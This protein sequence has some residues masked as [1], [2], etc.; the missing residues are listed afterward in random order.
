MIRHVESVACHAYLG[1]SGI[2]RM[3]ANKKTASPR[4]LS[5]L[6]VGAIFSVCEPLSAATITVDSDVDA[7]ISDGNC[8]LREAIISSNTDSPVDACTQGSGSDVI[9]LPAG[10]YILT[11]P[12]TN[13]NASADG[14]LDVTSNLTISGEDA[15]TTIIDGNGAITGERA[16]TIGSSGNSSFSVTISDVTI[17]NGA[18]ATIGGGILN[19]GNTTLTNIVVTGSTATQNGGGIYNFL[20][21]MTL[22]NATILQNTAATNGGGVYNLSTLTIIDSNVSNN[23][24]TT[25]FG[26]GIAA[27]GNNFTVTDSMI[28][29]NTAAISGGGIHAASGVTHI[30]GCTVSGNTVINGNGGGIYSDGGFEFNIAASTISGN[31]AQIGGGGV[32][33]G[34]GTALIINSIINGNTSLGDGGG[35][36]N[37]GALTVN[38]SDISENTAVNHGGGISNAANIA[39][40]STT[41]S[42]NTA[43]GNGGG[44]WNNNGGVQMNNVTITNNTA[45]NDADDSGDGGGLYTNIGL[46]NISNTLIA[47]NIDGSSSAE[48][49]DCL[50]DI[51]S[52]GNNIVG[53]DTGCNFT[54]NTGD[55]VGTTGNPVNPLLGPLADNGGDTRTHELLEESPAIDT[56]N[57]ASCE[58]QDQ[59]GIDRPQDGNN[60]NVAICD[61]GSFELQ[62]SPNVVYVDPVNPPDDLQMPF[63]RRVINTFPTLD[64][65]VTNSGRLDLL[66]RRIG[67]FERLEPP[68]SLDEDCTTAPIPPSGSCVITVQFSVAQVGQFS[69]SFDIITNDPDESIVVVDVSGEG[70]LALNNTPPSAPELIAPENGA[71]GQDPDNVDFQWTRADDPDNDTLTYSILLCTDA[72]LFICPDPQP[73]QGLTSSIDQEYLYAGLGTSGILFGLFG[74]TS[75]RIQRRTRLGLLILASLAASPLLISC[76]TGLKDVDVSSALNSTPLGVSFG[77]FTP[78]TTYYWRIDVADGKGGTASSNVRNF[79]TADAPPA[80]SQ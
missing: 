73:L 34:R 31:S 15:T 20:G 5:A 79:K 24:A 27:L 11:I 38:M 46:N 49:P 43:Q 48:V 45:D 68:F 23:T 19:Y 16:I 35:I 12:G 76:D 22:T 36:N 10:T 39:A 7:L 42:G 32:N 54:N 66:V 6:V 52:L 14:D 78:G 75:G 74:F 55:I 50:G 58:V 60:D 61:I 4:I 47:G 51:N 21:N 56:G 67:S 26:G 62:L 57:D 18:T 29:D 44:I 30:T 80:D 13:E 37:N 25:G 77:N 1:M 59:R 71:T 63:D 33:I 41:I 28:M 8:T 3:S 64:L 17:K 65:S 69:D 53:D 2:S 40:R 9:I 70:V 72:T